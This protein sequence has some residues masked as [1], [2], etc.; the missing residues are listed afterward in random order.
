MIPSRAAVAEVAPAL[1]HST[2]RAT[3]DQRADNIVKTGLLPGGRRRLLR[4]ARS[5][6]VF[7]R[8]PF[9]ES[10]SSALVVVRRL[11]K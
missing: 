1:I 4:P 10:V 9:P 5:R 3:G 6:S 7:R 8:D 11:G 2:P